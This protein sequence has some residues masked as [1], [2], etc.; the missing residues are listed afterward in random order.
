MSTDIN[1]VLTAVKMAML[2]FWAAFPIGRHFLLFFFPLS[3]YL[4]AVWFASLFYPHAILLLSFYLN[5]S[6]YHPF[7]HFLSL[8]R[9]LNTAVPHNILLQLNSNMRKRFH[10]PLIPSSYLA[11]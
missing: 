6:P 3:P 10:F 7:P 11:N 9:H 8:L 4:L 5:F 1:K 2:V